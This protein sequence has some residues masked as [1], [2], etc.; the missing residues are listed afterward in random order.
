MAALGTKNSDG[1]AVKLS[2]FEARQDSFPFISTTN[3]LTNVSYPHAY[4]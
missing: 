2:R 3:T 4:L 1:Q